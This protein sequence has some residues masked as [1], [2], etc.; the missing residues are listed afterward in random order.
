[1][2]HLVVGSSRS[3]VRPKELPGIVGKR[4]SVIAAVAIALSLSLCGVALAD[5]AAPIPDRVYSDGATRQS[6]PVAER[7]YSDGPA[8]ATSERSGAAPVAA[9]AA[10]VTPAAPPSDGLS[11][12]IIVLISIG[13]ALMLGAAAYL[14]MRV[15]YHGHAAA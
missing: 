1:M 3:P 6:G 15:V 8:V 11:A 10:A 9:P 12:F 5:T 13:G 14:T 2:R 4:C 7:T